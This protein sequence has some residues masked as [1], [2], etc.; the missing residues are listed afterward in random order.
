MLISLFIL[1]N[2]SNK[3]NIKGY[4]IDKENFHWAVPEHDDYKYWNYSNYVMIPNLDIIYLFG[5]KSMI[6]ATDLNY[7]N[8]NVTKFNLK[9]EGINISEIKIDKKFTQERLKKT[10]LF[11]SESHSDLCYLNYAD[12]N[13]PYP[14]LWALCTTND[15]PHEIMV[16][17]YNVEKEK[18][19]VKNLRIDFRPIKH[20]TK[21]EKYI[22]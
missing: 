5:G 16:L 10:L 7:E 20:K 3:D 8:F 17:E 11:N 19:F 1:K 13:N 2:S 15:D 22:I 18:P 4:D 21:V 6:E 9:M 12:E 14:I